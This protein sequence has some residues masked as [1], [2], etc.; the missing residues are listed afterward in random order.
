MLRYYWLLYKYKDRFQNYLSPYNIYI[1]TPDSAPSSEGA[2]YLG[3][4]WEFSAQA[5]FK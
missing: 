3:D 5:R 1:S 2:W 4:K